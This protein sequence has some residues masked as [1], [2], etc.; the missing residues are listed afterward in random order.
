MEEPIML[1][2]ILGV[3]YIAWLDS[4]EP[5]RVIKNLDDEVIDD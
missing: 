1:D 3:K 4:P 5:A 2:Y